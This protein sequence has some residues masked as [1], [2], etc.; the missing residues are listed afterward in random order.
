ME[1]ATG[2]GA[3]HRVIARARVVD[4]L[5]DHRV[6]EHGLRKLRVAAMDRRL[7]TATAHL[8][9]LRQALITHLFLISR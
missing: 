6:F 4:L 5:D 7:A 2:G 9:W 3:V 8:D 1:S